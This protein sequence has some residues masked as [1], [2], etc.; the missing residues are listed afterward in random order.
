[1]LVRLGIKDE[2]RPTDLQAD[3]ARRPG[4]VGGGQLLSELRQDLVRQAARGPWLAAGWLAA[5]W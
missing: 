5:G 1:M 4:G 3:A 2:T